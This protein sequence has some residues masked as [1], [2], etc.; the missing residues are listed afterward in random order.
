[1]L[2]KYPITLGKTV[3]GCGQCIHCRANRRREWVHRILLEMREHEFNTF[4]TLTYDNDYLPKDG[5]LNPKHL[6]DFFKRLRKSSGYPLRYFAV[7]EYGEETQR[8]HYHIAL[9][10]HPNC[11]YGRTRPRAVC[12]S[13]CTKVRRIWGK[14]NVLLGELNDH[15]AAYTAGYILKKMTNE[16]DKRLEGRYPEFA[17]MSR[18]PGIGATCVD[19]IASQLLT[20]NA[21]S[22][23]FF[24]KHGHKIMPLDQYMRDQ[25]A[26]K[27]L[28]P[29]QKKTMQEVSELYEEARQDGTPRELICLKVEHKVADQKRFK[30]AAI[31]RNL[32]RKRRRKTL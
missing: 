9:F 19:E 15:S 29:K 14:G 7:G 11:N 30:K 22:V 3:V 17:R 13:I 12:C 28:L 32:N 10:G 31:E 24:L 4:L 25:I 18:K 23:P 21:K 16:D 5:S 8:P 1:M 20:Y 6:T 27:T 2:C 26:K